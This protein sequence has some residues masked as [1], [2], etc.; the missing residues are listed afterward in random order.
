MPTPRLALTAA[1][2]TIL[3]ACGSSTTG[4]GSNFTVL[5]DSATTIGPTDGQLTYAAGIND[6]GTVVGITVDVTNIQ[7]GWQLKGGFLTFLSVTVPNA[8]LTTPQTINDSGYV[9]GYYS[10][11]NAYHGFVLKGGTYSSF[12]YPAAT[13]TEA[14]FDVRTLPPTEMR[15]E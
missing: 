7:Y 14:V 6:S 9:A 11:S 4:P 15:T 12:D 13:S 8:I 5:G 3:A 1:L 2:A 10:L